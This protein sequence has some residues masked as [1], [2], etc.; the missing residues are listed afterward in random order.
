MSILL[1][2]GDIVCDFEE[3]TWG[4][5]RFIVDQ[6]FG[7]SYCRMISTY[8]IGMNSRGV[9]VNIF[10]NTIIKAQFYTIAAKTFISLGRLYG[11]EMKNYVI[12]TSRTN[13]NNYKFE[14]F[15]FTSKSLDEPGVKYHFSP[16]TGTDEDFSIPI[17]INDTNLTLEDFS[18]I[19]NSI[20]YYFII[21]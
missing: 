13:S 15:Y 17:Q 5:Q 3:S 11:P 12:L 18:I 1:K 7:N 4:N 9:M 6:F 14:V 20:Y 8:K 21:K 16:Y 2:K 10:D 19:N